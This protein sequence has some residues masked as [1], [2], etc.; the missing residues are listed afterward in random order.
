LYVPNAFAPTTDISGVNVFKPVGVNL[1][2]YKVE[3]FDSWGHLL[4]E[5]S[6]L[7]ID[8]RPV[9][10]W[11]GRKSNGDL[12]QQGTYV[13]IIKAVFIDGTIWEGSDIGKGEYKS[14]GTVTLI[15]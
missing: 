2:Q 4:W 9:E 1:K 13:W 10:S 14:M 8:G 6:L 15:R 7:D 12:Y 3:V 5:S 11:N